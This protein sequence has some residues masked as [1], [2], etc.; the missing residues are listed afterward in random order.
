MLGIRWVLPCGW[1]SMGAAPAGLWLPLP[2]PPPASRA[3]S[4]GAAP[5]GPKRPAAVTPQ[6][7][8]DR[9]TGS[10]SERVKLR[11]MVRV[12]GVE[13]D[14]EGGGSGCRGGSLWVQGRPAAAELTDIENS[15]SILHLALP[16]RP[17][18]SRSGSGASTRRRASALIKRLLLLCC[19]LLHR[20]ADPAQGQEPDGE[21]PREAGRVPHAGAGAAARLHAAQ[22]GEG[23]LGRAVVSEGKGVHSTRSRLELQQRAFTLHRA[24]RPGWWAGSGGAQFRAR[25]GA[26]PWSARCLRAAG[27]RQRR[28]GILGL[29]PSHLRSDRRT[30]GTR[31]MWS[32]C[33]P[34]ATPR[35]PPTWQSCSLRWGAAPG[36]GRACECP[37]ER[38]S[39]AAHGPPLPR[40]AGPPARPARPAHT[41][42]P[43]AHPRPAR[44]RAAGGP[45]AP[46][47]GGLHL[48][49]HA[50]QDRGQ[51]PAQARRRG[52]GLRQ[53]HGELL[54]EG[55]LAEGFGS[56]GWGAVV[57]HPGA[58]AGCDQAMESLYEE[59][60][61][62]RGTS[63][64]VMGLA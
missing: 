34:P 23:M 55:G 47:P 50:G 19:R 59:V 10:E 38:C 29:P 28:T 15:L 13:Y 61:W 12:E 17:Q 63:R 48:H 5:E 35:P 37:H 54:R 31:W 36:G 46:V 45:G 42:R 22:G 26:R 44:R 43:P 3:A 2:L 8:T 56:V 11:L 40:P 9:G 14:A 53:G 25:P 57:G 1:C 33:A 52:G 64:A 16:T 27:L 49:A 39:P 24:P 4:P 60:G 51:H 41:P 18:A 6:V 20:P 7:Q 30:S 32:A 58:A 21:R 62:Q